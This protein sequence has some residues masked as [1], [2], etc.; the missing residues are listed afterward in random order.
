MDFGIPRQLDIPGITYTP[1]GTLYALAWKKYLTDRY[2]VNSKVM[3]C[4]V[5]LKGM[6]VNQ[7]LLRKFYYYDGCL[8][9]LN[10]IINYSLTTFDTI[11]CEF[12]QVQND[13]NYTEGQYMI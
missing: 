10:K 7:E 3:R 2:D 4:R 13:T 12:V 9:V 11:E 5:D 1:E 8:W 6:Q